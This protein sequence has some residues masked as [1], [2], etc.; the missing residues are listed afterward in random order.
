M[1]R[2]LDQVQDTGQVTIW[3]VLRVTFGHAFGVLGRLVLCIMLVRARSLLAVHF[4]CDRVVVDT[5]VDTRSCSQSI[6]VVGNGRVTR[7]RAR[8]RSLWWD[9]RL[10]S[11]D[12]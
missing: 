12:C 4:V 1:H 8:Y 10:L 5:F 9:T 3:M 7:Q 2:A 6:V 11:P